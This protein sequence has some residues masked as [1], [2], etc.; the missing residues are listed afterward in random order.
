MSLKNRY[1]LKE[2]L[3]YFLIFI[4]AFS[5]FLFLTDIFSG[6]LAYFRNHAQFPWR[7]YFTR[8]PHKVYVISP[9]ITL[10]SILFVF[11][12]I[13]KSREIEIFEIKGLR[14]LHI[15]NLFFIFGLCSAIFFFLLGNF[16]P[17]NLRTGGIKYVHL[18]SRN[19]VFWA[20]RY[21]P[22]GMFKNVVIITI[23]KKH[24]RLY[25]MQYAYPENNTFLLKNGEIRNL[26][27][28]SVSTKKFISYNLNVSFDTKKF[29]DFILLNVK[30]SSFFNALTVLKAMEKIG[31]FPKSKWID[32]YEK[33]AYPLL[34]FFFVFIMLPLF[35]NRN[36]FSRF[37]IFI[38]AIII[39]ISAYSIYSIGIALGKN[40]IINWAI[41]PWL[42]HIILLVTGI[43][44]L[45]KKEMRYI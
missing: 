24:L 30:K 15:L 1:I 29:M 45:L 8:L 5:V 14:P 38:L 9:L 18:A 16:F 27:N 34:N 6:I 32:L 39:S 4:V 43:I 22:S 17:E 25:Q 12:E 42:F 11:G 13:E 2:L 40:D 19:F 33:I 20:E 21:Y 41:S 36:V 28:P 23:Q 31:F 35:Y 26:I 44:Y 10:L 37:K 3:K 7:Y